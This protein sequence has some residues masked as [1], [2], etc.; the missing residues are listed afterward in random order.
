[1]KVILLE[2]VRSMGHRYEIKEVR[3]GYARNFLFPNKLAEPATPT[4]LKKLE[5]MKAEHNAKEIEI[6]K[7]LETI[8]HHISE[9]R[10]QFTLKQGKDGS[11]FGSINKEAILKALREHK[12][13]TKEHV[14]LTLDHPIKALGTYTI[15][16]DLKKGVTAALKIE[17]K[18]E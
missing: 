15:P 11:T 4:S 16:I 9:M 18:A 6:K 7:H 13:V 2:D 3:D 8:A 12:L 5:S 14:D 10:I 1:M 17:V